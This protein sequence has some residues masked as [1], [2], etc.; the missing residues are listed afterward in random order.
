MAEPK[1]H[2]ESP[3]NVDDHP[4]EPRDAWW[5]L[6]KIC[7]LAQAAHLTSTP[8]AI[9]MK[10]AHFGIN[11]EVR[12]VN[13]HDA[14]QAETKRTHQGGRARIGYVGDDIPDDE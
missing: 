7:G 8:R 5:S 11:G 2:D 13:G 1:A 9:E 6:C 3:P 10:K 14:R 12:Y 4:F